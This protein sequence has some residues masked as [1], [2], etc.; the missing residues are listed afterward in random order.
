LRQYSCK[1]EDD[2]KS[3][4][5]TVTLKH[6]YDSIDEYTVSGSCHMEKSDGSRSVACK[7]YCGG[8]MTAYLIAKRP[9]NNAQCIKNFNYRIE[10]RAK[11]WFLVRSGACL[12]SS[13]QI[14][15]GCLF[16]YSVDKVSSFSNMV[17]DEMHSS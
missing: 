17:E 9:A 13:I 7:T 15:V 10:Q 3:G 12:K 11:N 16:D 6:G 2:M 1:A 14:D 5:C 4:N 8:A